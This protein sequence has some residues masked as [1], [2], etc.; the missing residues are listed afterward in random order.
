MSLVLD[1]DP[2][3][4]TGH[5]GELLAGALEPD[6]IQAL[7]TG[8]RQTPTAGGALW[9]RA[10]AALTPRSVEQVRAVLRALYRR[11]GA[12]VHLHPVSTGR[13]WGFGGAEPVADG[14]VLLRLHR[15]RMIRLLDLRSGVA[16]VEPGVSQGELARVVAGSDWMLNVTASAAGTSVVGNALDRGVGLRRQRTGDLLGLEV[17]LADG[18]LVHV[19]RFP[20]AGL[21]NAPYPHQVGPGLAQLFVQSGFGVVTA[22]AVRLVPRPAVQQVLRLSFPA[23]RLADAVDFVGWAARNRMTTGVVKIFNAGA[24]ATYGGVAPAGY[25]AYLCVAGVPALVEA[26]LT[27]LGRAAAA[28]GIGEG[29]RRFGPGDPGTTV[30]EEATLR[31]Y[32]GD[33]SAN[34]AMVAHVFGASVEAADAEGTQGLLFF[35]PVLPAVAGAVTAAVELLDT[36]RGDAGP[37]VSV[38]HTVNVLP[39][40][41]V[42][43]VVAIRFR[44]EAAAAA[45]ARTLLDELHVRFAAAGF[46]PYRLDVDHMDTAAA[47]RG[48]PG[49]EELLRRLGGVLDP[50]ATLSR[51]RYAV[52]R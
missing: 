8:P 46:P 26:T 34:D 39:G 19:G 20:R 4:D 18:S 22:A 27:E 49:V 24:A 35:T 30:A 25:H 5:L 37:G 23:S 38:G 16:V 33:P 17:A 15:L 9:G 52:G 1:A 12:G 6:Q 41:W 11:D 42:D 28:K 50:N 45:R 14:A 36:I 48:E 10:A 7:P 29:R 51:G 44:R 13:N 21:A 3:L 40:S 31:A 2:A 32:A 43:L 47:L